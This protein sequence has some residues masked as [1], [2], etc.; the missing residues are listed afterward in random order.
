MSGLGE[1]SH[2]IYCRI[3][4]LDG[5]FS[6]T[7]TA[8]HATHTSPKMSVFFSCVSDGWAEASSAPSLA[9]GVADPRS[10]GPGSATTISPRPPL[11]PFSFLGPPRDVPLARPGHH[12]RAPSSLPGERPRREASD[13]G[14][15]PD[16]GSHPPSRVR[17]RR[18]GSPRSQLPLFDLWIRGPGAGRGS[19]CTKDP[20]RGCGVRGC[21][22]Y[23]RAAGGQAPLPQR[24]WRDPH[25]PQCPS[26]ASAGLAEDAGEP[27]LRKDRT[28][29]PRAERPR[30]ARCDAQKPRP[31]TPSG[32]RT[33]AAAA[34][35]F[36]GRRLRSE[37]WAHREAPLGQE[38]RP[39]AAGPFAGKRDPGWSSAC[40]GEEAVQRG[41]PVAL[42]LPAAPDPLP[43][44]ACEAAAAGG[45]S[46]TRPAGR[47]GPASPTPRADASGVSGSQTASP[48]AT[49]GPPRLLHGP[50]AAARWDL[51]PNARSS[52]SPAG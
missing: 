7:S 51:T 22:T 19:C 37:A 30:R 47:R 24:G 49:V 34:T 18:H 27:Q 39:G 42:L 50:S 45:F 17:G 9:P 21:H 52:A 15:T 31:Q 16:P 32:G 40:Y 44:T 6:N 48:G 1:G 26:T 4:C 8:K 33:A 11:Q 28:A 36:R 23:R 10:P 20:R 5:G 35:G 46:V 3:V 38:G 2:Q 14:L 12:G 43:G 41:L 13:R 25:T 29:Q